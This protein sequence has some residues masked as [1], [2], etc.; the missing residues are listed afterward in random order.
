MKNNKEKKIKKVCHA[1]RLL[2]SISRFLGCCCFIKTTNNK[3]EG[4]SEQQ[5]L[6]TT[7]LFNNGFTLIELL[8]VVLIIG[9]LAAIALP[10]YQKAVE[11]TRLT[12]YMP[13]V[14][15]IHDAEEAYYLANGEYSNDLEALDIQIPTAGCTYQTDEQYEGAY[16]SCKGYSIGR[17][18]GSA[19]Y[20][21]SNIAY[22]H[23]FRHGEARGIV[24]EKG[25]RWCYSKT[26]KYRNICKSLG[27]GTEYEDTPWLYKWKLD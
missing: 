1:E 2:L 25:S 27:P 7:A 3:K 13:L 21:T 4:G 12:T 8:V 14:R 23:Q 10:Q 26:E 5:H 20:Q 19:Q 11:K 16:Y 15:A 9:I 6:R 18:G 22:L 17:W 24:Y